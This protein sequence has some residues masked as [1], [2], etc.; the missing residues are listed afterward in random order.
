MAS[1][2]SPNFSFSG[3]DIWEFIKGRKKMIITAIGSICGYFAF[4]QELTALIIG[5]IFEAVWSV[6]EYW[7]KRISNKK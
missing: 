4:G 6:A 3:W 2:T 1:K 7:F 5:P